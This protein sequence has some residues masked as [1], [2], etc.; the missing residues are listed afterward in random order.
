VTTTSSDKVTLVI[1]TL[2][3][4]AK[5]GVMIDV[6][7]TQAN[8]STFYQVSN[9]NNVFPLYNSKSAD[10]VTLVDTLADTSINTAPQVYTTGGVLAD[11]APPPAGPMVVH[12]NRMFVVD[13]TNPTQIWYS[14]IVVP[15]YPVEFSGL[16][17]LNIDPKGGPITA[18]A[19][20]DDKLIIF[21]QD[22]I[23]M[24]L[25]Q[26]PD[27]TG[28]QNDYTDAILVNADTGVL[29]PKSV[30]VV[31]D[32]LMFQAS[33]PLAQGQTEGQGSFYL[34]SR[35]LQLSYIGAP[36]EN[37]FAIQCVSAVLDPNYHMVRFTLGSVQS[38]CIVYDYLVGQW[39]KFVT[40]NGTLGASPPLDA[41][42]W[43]GGI[44]GYPQYVILVGGSCFY[45]SVNSYYDV[46]NGG[47]GYISMSLS[48]GW[49]KLDGLQGF[50]RV[51]RAIVL[52]N[53]LSP[54]TLTVT[55][56]YDYYNVVPSQ[57]T[58]FAVGA[59]TTPYQY[60]IHLA[61]QKC[62]AIQLTV[63]DSYNG[64]DAPFPGGLTL[65]GLQL[66]IGVKK[67]LRRIPAT[68]TGG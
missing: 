64:V 67:G 5:S 9:F 42:S 39:S 66:E 37:M 21:K 17:V 54:H 28:G 53:Y 47:S 23:F 63:A 51:R 50:Q 44:N 3:A 26:G 19:S 1:P 13:S 7:R 18:L 52:G 45:D 61:K 40:A 65:S 20:L 56:A 60:M 30:V 48:T 6:Y 43:T 55:A 57:T 10:T 58:T 68:Q 34:L 11:Y 31:P 49:I 35:A 46:V 59:D 36:V 25:G 29:F 41:T 33:K 12:R 62:E 16:Q 32:G 38:F 27:S 8:L 2:R 22:R 15:P 14:K 24:V 4:T